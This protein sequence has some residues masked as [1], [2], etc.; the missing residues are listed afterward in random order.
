MSADHGLAGRVGL[1][2]GATSEIG[3]ACVERLRG[4]GMTLVEVGGW[5]GDRARA[6]RDIEAAL[7]E[8][9]GRIDVLVSSTGPA[10]DGSLEA[11]G[12]A[13]FASLVESNLTAAFRAG[14]A[15][16][17]AMRAGGGG[18]MIYVASD[19]GIRAAHEQAAD[20]V[21]SAGVIAVAELFAAE[22]AAYAI[23]A[24]AVCPGG[25]AAGEDIASVVAW[26]ASP[27]SAHVSGATIRLDGAAGAAI[28]ADTRG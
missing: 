5:D 16:F 18:S 19:A 13:E 11:T 23:R 8:T 2:A 10:S 1:V 7:T 12:E 27:Q 14:R 6:D 4:E 21:T 24:N 15:C 17:A 20:S 28:V 3:R 22:G 26:L 25:S 9:A